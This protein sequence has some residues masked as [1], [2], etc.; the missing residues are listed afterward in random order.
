MKQVKLNRIAKK[1]RLILKIK[2]DRGGYEADG[3]TS[4]YGIFFVKN[5]KICP[6]SGF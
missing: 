2:V 1:D 3:K 4:F 6:G 5:L